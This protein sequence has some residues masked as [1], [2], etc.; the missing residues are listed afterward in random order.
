VEAAAEPATDA[1]AVAEAEAG[2]SGVTTKLKEPTGMGQEAKQQ[3][4][5]KQPDWAKLP[6]A[7]LEQ[8]MAYVHRDS[9]RREW[10]QRDKAAAA[11]ESGVVSASGAARL[12]CRRWQKAHDAHVVRLELHPSLQD[13]RSRDSRDSYSVDEALRTLCKKM[14]KVR[15][16]RFRQ[17]IDATWV[18]PVK[19]WRVERF[20]GP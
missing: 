16:A 9:V 15:A 3:K 18:A 8:I 14:P 4:Q 10:T 19:I 11:A 17:A 20:L 5:Q 13:L 7:L 2:G 12:A 1:A 6:V